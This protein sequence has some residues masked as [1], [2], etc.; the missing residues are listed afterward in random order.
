[1]QNKDKQWKANLKNFKLRLGYSDNIKNGQ[2]EKFLNSYKK[3]KLPSLQ[4]EKTKSP[5]AK[6]FPK[7]EETVATEINPNNNNNTYFDDSSL[8]SIFPFFENK[9]NTDK[10]NI[11]KKTKTKIDAIKLIISKENVY[12]IFQTHQ[13]TDFFNKNIHKKLFNQILNENFYTQR[14]INHI[15]VI[16]KDKQK[17]IKKYQDKKIFNKI[18]SKEK[19]K[20][21]TQK[22][23]FVDVKVDLNNKIS[24]EL[25]TVHELKKI[26]TFENNNFRIENSPN[27]I[28]YSHK[29]SFYSLLQNELGA[30]DNDLNK[31]NNKNE[32]S[33]F[34]KNKDIDDNNNSMISC[35]S[36]N[37]DNI[38]DISSDFSQF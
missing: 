6:P 38:K 7:L 35:E 26:V 27:K 24:F 30:R 28:D 14:E 13:N 33:N 20:E 8:S 19:S 23:K 31:E 37:S 12:N 10:N 36:I 1:M 25:I 2:N 3:E 22:N 29:N 32:I 5:L 18:I 4:I 17:R 11:M 34:N 9:N 15:D 21:I 16:K